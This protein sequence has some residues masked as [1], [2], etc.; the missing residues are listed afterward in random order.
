MKNRSDESFV[1]AYREMYEELEARGFKPKLNVIDNESSKAVQRYITSQN[2][3][4]LVV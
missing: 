3:H 1:E 4:Y 2:V